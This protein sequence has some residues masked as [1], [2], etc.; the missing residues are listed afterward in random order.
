[1]FL[2]LE[3]VMP[4][5]T[6]LAPRSSSEEIRHFGLRFNLR[7]DA[8]RSFMATKQ[9]IRLNCAPVVN[10]F[11]HSADPIRRS[12]GVVDYQLKPAGYHLHYQIY[13]VKRI[14]G[15]TK[16][17]I[18]SYPLLSELDLDAQGPFAQLCRRLHDGELKTYIS[19]SDSG[20]TPSDQTLIIDLL[21]SNGVLVEG[22]KV[23]DISLPSAPYRHLRCKNITALTPLA[24]VPMGEELHW[25]LVK[26][27]ALSQR[28]LNTLDGLKDSIQLY[29]FHVLVNRQMARGHKLLLDSLLS[30]ES[31][32]IQF[33]YRRI[34]LWGQSNHV[35]IDE[36][37]FDSESELFLFGTILDEF[38]IQQAPLNFFSEL[39][40]HRAQSQDSYQWPKRLGAQIL[41]SS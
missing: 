17:G 31:K 34:P 28:D 32:N 6:R 37:A 19:L 11:P 24:P 41:R 25:R 35:K 26:H 4:L 15:V 9:N 2:S 33:R 38:F 7:V 21:C 29:N 23:G 39:V 22:L 14:K 20:D 13:Q 10:L 36:S 18:T 3:E 8:A 5:L 30:L 1:M 27:M 12:P 40:I 16:Q